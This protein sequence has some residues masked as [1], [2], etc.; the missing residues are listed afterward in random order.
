M[1]DEGQFFHGFVF[2]FK[3]FW[4]VFEAIEWMMKVGYFLLFLLFF[5]PMV[6]AQTPS[7]LDRTKLA[8][9]SGNSQQMAL[10]MAEKLQFGFEGEGV[11]MPS[12]TAESQL[13]NFYKSH[14][15]TELSQL[16]QGQSKDGK[17]YFIGLLKTKNG[18]FRASVYWVEVPKVQIMSI[19]FSKE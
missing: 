2:K 1:D 11:F 9:K 15:V 13:M 3:L 14:P 17:Q 8:L 19:D 10:M 18:N 5:V 7:A 16:F 4:L 12:K 6:Q